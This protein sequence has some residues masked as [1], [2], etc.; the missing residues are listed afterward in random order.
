MNCETLAWASAS[1]HLGRA[2]SLTQAQKSA[3]NS[4]S[5]MH[6]GQDEEMYTGISGGPTTMNLWS[7]TSL[8][9]KPTSK[10]HCEA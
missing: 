3:I 9:K 1:L 4:L 5:R 2:G 7:H 10:Q 8:G 6:E